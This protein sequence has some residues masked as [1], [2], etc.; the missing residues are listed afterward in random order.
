MIEANIYIINIR[1][2]ILI[3]NAFAWHHHHEVPPST[4]CIQIQSQIQN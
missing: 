3:L 2:Y 1:S 4:I